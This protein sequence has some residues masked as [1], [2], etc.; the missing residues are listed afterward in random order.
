MSSLDSSGKKGI[1]L[2]FNYINGCNDDVINLKK[3]LDGWICKDMPVNS[4]EDLEKE[5]KNV[6]EEQEHCFTDDEI[7]IVFFYG[8]GYENN[9]YPKDKEE[10]SNMIY[11]GNKENS[12]S[13]SYEL[14]YKKIGKLLSINNSLI[15]FTNICLKQRLRGYTFES[16]VEEKE[17][18]CDNNTFHFITYVIEGTC[19]EGSLMTHI[20]LHDLFSCSVNFNKFANK[21]KKKINMRSKF[22]GGKYLS[23]YK[24]AKK[25]FKKDDDDY[26]FSDDD[27]DDVLIPSFMEQTKPMENC[28]N[29]GSHTPIFNYRNQCINEIYFT[30]THK[31]DI[32]NNNILNYCNTIDEINEIYKL[33]SPVI[34]DYCFGC[35]SFFVL[36]DT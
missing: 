34:T 31:I 36:G 33:E 32:I 24:Y 26:Y 23:Y 29:P 18:K 22:K 9:T 3:R 5:L 28:F 11:L 30:N 21:L 15:L 20:L 27:D 14:F 19:D 1:A 12:S 17:N 8:Y 2:F 35:T 16:M 6:K 13:I 7:V 25:N 4:I 10:K